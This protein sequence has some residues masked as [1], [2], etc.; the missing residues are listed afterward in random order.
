MPETLH[1]ASDHAGFALKAL[2]IEHLVRQGRNVRDH[3]TDSIQSC[4]YPLFAQAVCK[5]LPERGELGILICGSGIG[6]S[7]MANRFHGIRA[8]VCSNEFLAG[9]AR[10]HNNAN[11]LCLGARV[12]GVDLALAIVDAFLQNTFEGG[13]HQRRI[14][15]FDD[16]ADD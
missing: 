15:M 5:A 11:V 6:M 14:D 13:R 9:A 8:A 3:G 4:D 7:I 10:R 1:I 16:E 12:I 2:V